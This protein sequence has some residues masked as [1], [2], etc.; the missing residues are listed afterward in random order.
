MGW[1]P[2]RIHYRFTRYL[3]A[4][5][6]TVPPLPPSTSRFWRTFKW[7]TDR[8]QDR[9]GG[10]SYGSP[11]KKGD[12]FKQ[13]LL[14]PPVRIRRRAT[15]ASSRNR[16][17]ATV[18]ATMA[19]TRRR[20]TTRPRT[21]RTGSW[22]RRR[23]R[24]PR[25]WRT[26][27]PTTCRSTC[28]PGGPSSACSSP[29]RCCSCSRRPVSGDG[30]AAS[31]FLTFCEQRATRADN[32]YAGPVIGFRARFFYQPPP[33]PARHRTRIRKSPVGDGRLSISRRD[34]HGQARIQR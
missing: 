11:G 28:G 15:T 8:H 4:K 18:S 3:R 23:T 10:R 26:A 21:S 13:N 9:S 31:V 12:F 14:L 1:S 6:W 22:D 5:V 7:R 17:A 16:C 33:S 32:V 20:S 19:C 29:R 30:S 34:A 24:S 25:A 27:R 2:K